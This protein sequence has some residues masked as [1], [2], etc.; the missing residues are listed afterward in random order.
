MLPGLAVRAH[1]QSDI[2]YPV[3]PVRIVVPVTPGGSTDIL[4]R[5]VAQR[6]SEVWR[7]QFIVENR[8]GAGGIIAVEYVAKSVPDGYT[9]V[10]GFTG[11]FAHMPAILPKIGY[12][13]VRDFAPV[14][15]IATV[16][17]MLAVHPSIPARTVKEL[18]AVAKARPGQLNYGSAGSG[19]NSHVSVEFFKQ[20]TGTDIQQIAYKGAG[21][22]MVDLLGGHISLTIVG[23]PPLLPHVRSGRL[24]ALGVGTLQRLE[25]LPDV[26]TIAEAGVPGYDVS[27]WFGLMAPSNAPAEIVR[28]LNAEV[29]RYLQLPETRAKLAAEGAIPG[30]GTSEQFHDLIKREVSRWAVVLKKAGI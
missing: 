21:S 26:P 4:A 24:R 28:K 15:H 5:L 27:Q 2:S 16:P 13:P 19:S 11:T 30:G 20:L 23:I 10:L 12:D 3:K 9:L 7:T 1:A 22:T 14:S 25:I 18:I 8:P 17:N 6:L 29:V